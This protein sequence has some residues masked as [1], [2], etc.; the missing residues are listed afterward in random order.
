MSGPISIGCAGPNENGSAA[1]TTTVIH[2]RTS[3]TCGAN[4]APRLDFSERSNRSRQLREVRALLLRSDRKRSARAFAL[5]FYAGPLLKA[6]Q[7]EVAIRGFDSEAKTWRSMQGTAFLAISALLRPGLSLSGRALTSCSRSKSKVS[8]QPATVRRRCSTRMSLS[9]P[10]SPGTRTAAASV[11]FETASH[12][13]LSSP[14]AGSVRGLQVRRERLVPAPPAAAA[15]AGFRCSR[16]WFLETCRARMQ[17]LCLPREL[18]LRCFARPLAMSARSFSGPR[19]SRC[20]A[21]DASPARDDRQ[22]ADQRPRKAFLT[23]SWEC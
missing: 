22:P 21:M 13:R 7:A 18:F 19:I 5:P 6:P 15:H 11:R 1:S 23:T 8:D 14:G 4:P 16:A 17:R 20:L 12:G 2:V 3:P 9:Y 10:V